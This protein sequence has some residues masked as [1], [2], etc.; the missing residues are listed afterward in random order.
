MMRR[1]NT[2]QVFFSILLFSGMILGM[3]QPLSV[4]AQDA[5][6]QASSI[7]VDPLVLEQI[8]ANGAASYWV[9][10]TS[11]TD[12]KAAESMEWSKR[13]WY[14][15]EQLSK[16]AALSQANIAAYLT[17]AGVKYKSYWI[18]NTLLVTNS[19]LTVLN[20]L[21]NF[22][23]VEA[24]RARQEYQ[25]YEPE[26]NASVQDNGV[27]AIEPN[28]THI[29]AD[30]AWA[31]G[32]TGAGVVVA[33]IDTGVRYT[34]DALVNQ[35]RGN[36]GG[37]G[38]THNYNWFDPYNEYVVP[39]D[40]NGHGT[41]TMGTMVGDDGGANQIGIA[42]GAD[43]MACRGCNTS[44][45][46]DVALLTCAEFIAAPTDVNGNNPNP[47]MR[48]D[49]V[50][51]SWGD[52]SQSYDG[53]YQT[54]VNAWQAGGI[55]PIFSNGNSSNCGYPAPPGLGTVGNPAR[56][57]NVTGVG[58]SGRDNGQYA[59]FS[60]WGPSDVPDTVN[61]TPGFAYMK[62]QVL[63]PGTS[64]RSS[65]PGSDSSYEGGWSGTSMA[66]PHVTGLVALMWQA[67]P[68]LVGDYATTESMIEDSAVPV[69]YDD[70]SADTPTNDPNYAAGWGEIDALAAVQAAANY[71]GDSTLE[72]TVSD[73]GSGLPIA[74]ASVSIT[75]LDPSNNRTVL[76]ADNGYY[77]AAVF[78]DTFDITAA[79]FGYN[80]VT[81]TGVVLNSGATV[82]T[83]FALTELPTSLVSGFVYDGGIEGAAAHGY[84]LYASLTFAATGF[85]Q[86]IY[87]DP[88]TGAY[89][90]ELYLGQEYNVTV[91]AVPGGYTPFTGLF[92][93]DTAPDAQDYTLYITGESCSAPGY[94]PDYEFF[95]DFESSASGFTP[96][97]TTSFAWGDFTSGPGAGHS[98]TKGLATNPAGGYNSNE[99]GWI[100]SPPIDL[101]G[102]GA[103][104]PA[105]QWWDW[106][107]IESASYDWARLDVT[108]DSGATWLTVWGP[109]GGLHDSQYNQQTVILDPT[110]N[111]A[112]FQFRFYF[113]TD[114]SVEY[115]GWY[116]DDVGIARIPLPAPTTVWSNDL[117]ADNG[118]FGI[119]GTASS[120]AWGA[121]TTGPGAAHS[122]ANVW[123]TN[124]T[125]NYNASEG[126]YITSPVIDLSAYAG[127]VPT[128]AFWHWMDSESNSYDWSA[129]EVTNNGG[130]TWNTVYEK[131]GDVL[132]WTY[133]TVALD[134]S[135]AVSNFQFRF[136][137][138]SDTSLQYAGWYIDDI[139]V[140][141]AE[142]VEL[143]VPCIVVPGGVVAGYVS[144]G[145][146]TD[147]LT[148]ATVA[149]ETGVIATT[150]AIPADPINGFYWLFQPTATNPQDVSFTASMAD[151]SDDSAVVSVVADTITRQDFVLDS[152]S[153]AFD[154]LSLEKTMTMGDAPA[155]DL[156]T[157]TNTGLGVTNIELSERDRGYT[158]LSIPPFFGTVPQSNVPT[159]MG[160]A[161][162]ATTATPFGAAETFSQ[163]FAGEPAFA[164][165]LMVDALYNI[166]DTT[167]PGTWTEVG[168]TASAL[169]AGDFTGGDFTTL[170]AV[171]YDNGNLYAMDTTT[172]AATPIGPT[173]PPGGETF[174]GLTGEPGGEL[175][176]LTT[177][178][179]GSSLVMVDPASGATTNLGALPGIDCGIDLAY[180]TAEDMI[181]IV[182]IVSNN[183]FRV[184]PVTL[185]VTN[186]GALGYDAN[187]AQGMDYEETTG[188]LYWAA[189]STSGELRVIDMTTGASSPVGSFPGGTEVD[190][191][192]FATGGGGDVPWFSE[193]PVS[194]TIASGD[195]LDVTVTFDPASLAQPGDYEG[196]I[197]VNHDTPYTYPNIPVTLHLN[198]PASWGRYNGTVSGMERCDVNPAAL[199]GATVN[200]YDSGG[201][202]VTTLT[203]D[204]LG[205]YT[206][207]LANGAYDLEVSAAGYASQVI[208]DVVV[209]AGGTVSTDFSLRLNAPCLAV[210]PAELVQTQSPNRIR[211]QTLTINNVGAAAGS[212]NLIEM[213]LNPTI[214]ADVEL[215]LDDGSAED[216]IGLSAGGAFLWFNRFTP[217]PAALPFTLD[218]VLTLFNDTVAL[219]D[220]MQ[221]VV[222]SDTDSDPSN[223]AVYLGGETFTVVNNDLATWNSFSLTEP[224]LIDGTSDVLIGFVNRSGAAGYSD[225]PAAIDQNASQGR[226]WVALY[227]GDPPAEPPLPSDDQMAIVDDLGL[228]GNWT[229]RG[230]GSSAISD[231]LWL[232]ERPERGSVAGDSSRAVTVTFDS[233]GLALGDYFANLRVRN[234]P[235]PP[236]NVP[237]TLHVV[238]N[239]I[240]VAV[241]DA[242][243]ILKNSVLG[244]SAENGLLAND[245]DALDD[246][247]TVEVVDDVSHGTLVWLPD[248]FFVYVPAFEF[249]GVDSFSYRSFDGEAYSDTVSVTI[250]VNQVLFYLYLPD[251]AH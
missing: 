63:A 72:G 128:I 68:C 57:G 236:A 147:P 188:I 169:F 3:V 110:Y 18:K 182:D 247:L 11:Q 12:L 40:A 223:G 205:Y 109:F 140:T 5:E 30:D 120:W 126:S 228:P 117:E 84:P 62:P 101:T 91:S 232:E 199:G 13:G 176:G 102:F 227:S 86:T 159:S 134:P 25:V 2:A 104:T 220:E 198:A 208:E 53:W 98:G 127:Q 190:S 162:N 149:S 22:P 139:A 173:T 35:Y 39:T 154:P 215:I 78:A 71:C 197:K 129:V 47:D 146:T 85:S 170:Y 121:P 130:A 181:Y 67:A 150:F 222:Y 152:G 155:S 158:P 23:E 14:V 74:G 141:V 95:Y 10:I 52:C 180:N 83:N 161:P 135:Y 184:D 4:T 137:M 79:R 100:A 218:E 49:A 16:A 116:V 186:V 69:I 73:A 163:I 21:L 138:R 125:G 26:K 19:D 43:W 177:S 115:D 248:G 243:S 6:P 44:S 151:Y 106:K 224:I 165:D 202:L 105:I 96:G 54:V 119:S 20:G 133:K 66:A 70:G 210:E 29:N 156:L 51:N 246:P 56:Y 244:V 200:I 131:F 178:C 90:I 97:G 245:S 118:G 132:A 194:G 153:L 225:F 46:T 230:M 206:W 179:A 103:D 45:C 60:N 108:K 36:Q 171:S 75:G 217:N 8:E 164:V 93:P 55:Y 242:Y 50:N 76:T 34:H 123:A 82:T 241:P 113:K 192:A 77:S 195:S 211:Q 61:P 235:Y 136:F 24:I 234:A 193:D 166:P 175:Y 229:I 196:E 59:T 204:G 94:E 167:A 122:G 250:T 64:I 144:D 15:Y 237:V 1:S 183:L 42:P 191:L 185:A 58:A 231:I 148:G 112:D 249:V 239:A 41:H 143:A 238:A 48:P 28:L 89:E 65:V 124:L 214:N 142:S 207:W 212:F 213:S 9:D 114:S 201:A 38:F 81:Q 233:A 251:L 203:T 31:L 37:G 209:G 87:T 187:Y 107:W 221:L 80:P 145:N 27:N 226:S 32:Y 168:P 172:G 219:G 92:T 240:P 160:R 111:V 88:F 216:S 189:Y 33:S 7:T 17:D 157:I 99:L 174:S